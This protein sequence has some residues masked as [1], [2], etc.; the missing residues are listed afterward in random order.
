VR[1]RRGKRVEGE[2]MNARDVEDQGG[3]CDRVARKRRESY[4]QTLQLDYAFEI[5]AFAK[6]E[7]V[8]RR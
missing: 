4:L 8:L 5:L 7:K 6:R 2:Q 1:K 3:D